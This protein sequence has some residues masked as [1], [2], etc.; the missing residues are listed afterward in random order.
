MNENKFQ[1]DLIKE[2]KHKL[3]KAIVL[4]NDADYIQGIPDLIVLYKKHWAALECK[5][6]AT[7][8]HRPNQDYYVKG[9]DKMSFARFIWPENKEEVLNDMV[10]S[11]KGVSKRKS[12]AVQ[13]KS[14]GMEQ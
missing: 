13:S 14:A 3:P 10:K 12:C 6:S 2:I 7:A 9:M 1:A 4:K 5:K 11:L 8:S